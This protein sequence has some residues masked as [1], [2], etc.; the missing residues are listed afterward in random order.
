[1]PVSLK[2]EKTYW[3]SGINFIAGIDEA[4]RGPLAGPIVAA[5]VIFSSPVKIPGIDDSKKLSAQKRQELFFKIQEKA[6]STG[7]GIVD[8]KAIDKINIGKANILAME[9]AVANLRVRPSFL[10]LDGR[11]K[12]NSG[13]PQK[14]I[15]GGDGICFSIAAASIIAKV[16]RDKMMDDYHKLYPEYGFIR[17]KGYGTKEHLKMIAKYGACPIH[18][19]TFSPV[20]ALAECA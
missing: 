9:K 3:K 10:L 19:R 17:H 12:I 5:A 13:V 16:T 2:F 1:M 18:R 20:S 8:H 15:I 6:L 7:I 14:T 11:L 4:G